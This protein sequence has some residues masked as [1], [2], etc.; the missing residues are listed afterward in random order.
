[1]CVSPG[2]SGAWG[3]REH[4]QLSK[5]RQGASHG[6]GQRYVCWEQLHLS[7]QISV[8]GVCVSVSVNATATCEPDGVR[9]CVSGSLCI[10]L[11]VCEWMFV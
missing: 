6:A 3:F 5:Y 4:P 8:Y 11:R 7:G 2:V 1:M 9:T 10:P